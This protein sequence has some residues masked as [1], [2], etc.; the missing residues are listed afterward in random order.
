VGVCAQN[1]S[2]DSPIPFLPSSSIDNA[3]PPEKSYTLS[4]NAS[5]QNNT[6][7]KSDKGEL[8]IKQ[9]AV[10]TDRVLPNSNIQV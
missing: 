3:I 6:E 8:T 2:T 1:N 10:G 5:L 9:V 7:Q 4:N